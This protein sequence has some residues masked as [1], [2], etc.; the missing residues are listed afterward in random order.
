MREPGMEKYR[1]R[2]DG[3]IEAILGNPE[4]GWEIIAANLGKNNPAVSPEYVAVHPLYQ[5][6]FGEVVGYQEFIANASILER[7]N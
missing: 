4:A 1:V 6:L 7:S 5:R 2:T 3:L